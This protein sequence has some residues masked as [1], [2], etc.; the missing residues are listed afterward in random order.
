[1]SGIYYFFY[2]A[3][4]QS[5]GPYDAYGVQLATVDHAAHRAGADPE[6][7]GRFFDGYDL[8]IA[9]GRC[10]RDEF[11]GMRRCCKRPCWNGRRAAVTDFVGGIFLGFNW[12][13]SACHARTVH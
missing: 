13:R 7:G 1:M 12:G 9:D 3:R 8:H 11:G 10:Q 2:V 5:D 6:N 4:S